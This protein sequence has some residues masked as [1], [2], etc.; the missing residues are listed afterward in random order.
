MKGTNRG[1][2]EVAEKTRRGEPGILVPFRLQLHR[3]LSFW[4]GIFVAAFIGWAWWDSFHREAEIAYSYFA[5][6]HAHGGLRIGREDYEDSEFRM[7]YRPSRPWPHDW[8]AFQAPFF[9]D[10]GDAV[11]KIY[12]DGD[13]QPERRPR[14]AYLSYL[15]HLPRGSWILF[16]PHWLLLSALSVPWFG[17]LAWRTRRWRRGMSDE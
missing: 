15:N 14:D 3:S 12:F 16:I 4:T 5:V 6:G 13:L 7:S 17:F 10:V 11:K 8:G 2:A 1:G 9:A